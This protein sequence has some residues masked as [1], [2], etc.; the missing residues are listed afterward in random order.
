[1]RPTISQVALAWHQ[2]RQRQPQRYRS[3]WRNKLR[4]ARDGVQQMLSGGEF[5]RLM[6]GLVVEADGVAVR[7]PPNTQ[8]LIVLNIPSY[9]GGSDLWG[10]GALDDEEGEDSASTTVNH[11]HAHQHHS[12][13]LPTPVRAST[14]DAVEFEAVAKAYTGANG[15][16]LAHQPLQHHLIQRD[17]QHPVYKQPPPQRPSSANSNGAFVPASMDDQ[18]LEVVTVQGV[19]Q[20]GLAQMSLSGARRLCQCSRLTIRSVET[21]PMQAD[22]EPFELEP[23]LAPRKPM[24]IS[25]RHHDQAV[26]LSRSRVRADGVALEALDW[27]LH[28]GVITVEQRNKVLREVARRTGRLQ[29][30]STSFGSSASLDHLHRL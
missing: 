25:V 20:L 16:L 9:G 27:A 8:G 30:A 22:G 14:V 1:M 13:R 23:F 4:Y 21:L 26:M 28:E 18:L 11:E 17:H 12:P 6:S 7:L 5:S 24:T 3:R 2:R 10:V 29:R 15:T 19:L